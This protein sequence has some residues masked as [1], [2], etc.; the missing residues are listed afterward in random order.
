MNNNCF[1]C[2]Q[3]SCISRCY[4][5][6]YVCDGEYISCYDCSWEDCNDGC[7]KYCKYCDNPYNNKYCHK[8][9]IKK[10]KKIKVICNH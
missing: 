1:E 5:P 7:Y 6:I 9:C 4:N 8:K 10:H 2:Y 3:E